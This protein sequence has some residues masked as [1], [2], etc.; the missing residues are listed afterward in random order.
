MLFHILRTIKL[1]IHSNTNHRISVRTY[2]VAF[3]LPLFPGR[4]A[5][6]MSVPLSKFVIWNDEN[7]HS[8]V[9]ECYRKRRIFSCIRNYKQIRST[10]TTQS[11]TSRI[12]SFGVCRLLARV[13]SHD[14]S[15]TACLLHLQGSTFII[16]SF[17][18]SIITLLRNVGFRSVIDAVLC[19]VV[20]QPSV[21]A[22]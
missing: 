15:R 13:L 9:E 1:N 17:V 20:L 3:N 7:T 4:N 22:L 19:S 11:F 21:A 14:V 16:S 6:C 8:S 2:N 12:R 18:V 10:D 5:I